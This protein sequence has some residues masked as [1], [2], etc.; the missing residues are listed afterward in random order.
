M[1]LA[2]ANADLMAKLEKQTVSELVQKLWDS[3]ATA[4]EDPVVQVLG[5]PAILKRYLACYVTDIERRIE[6]AREE[7]KMSIVRSL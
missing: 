4:A 7:G 1:T 2:A 3:A 6:A 5:T